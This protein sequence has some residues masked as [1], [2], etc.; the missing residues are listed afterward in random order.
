[1]EEKLEPKD[2][3]IFCK[4]CDTQKLDGC[5]IHRPVFLTFKDVN[6]EI[7]T[8]FLRRAGLGVINKGEKIPDQVIFGPYTGEFTKKKQL[9]ESGNAWEIFNPDGPGILG[10]V[11]PGPNPDQVKHWMAKVNSANKRDEQNILGFQWRKQIYYR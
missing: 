3:Y 2:A 9:P 10:Y 11:D 8:S 1:M 6:L 4:P 7:K 5:D